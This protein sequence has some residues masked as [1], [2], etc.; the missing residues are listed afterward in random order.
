MEIWAGNC[1]FLAAFSPLQ[2]LRRADMPSPYLVRKRQP[3]PKPFHT[4]MPHTCGCLQHPTKV[5]SWACKPR[6]LMLYGEV[7]AWGLYMHSVS[8]IY[9]ASTWHGGGH[10]PEVVRGTG[11]NTKPRGG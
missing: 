1:L 2:I 6:E 3:T 5:G 4:L 7:P 11:A 9:G 10:H 8:Q